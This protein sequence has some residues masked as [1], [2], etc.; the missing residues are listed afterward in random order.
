MKINKLFLIILC[1]LSCKK[2]DVK[3][4]RF[5]SAKWLYYESNFMKKGFVCNEVNDSTNNICFNENLDIKEEPISDTLELT[6]YSLSPDGKY[7]CR[8]AQ[9]LFIDVFG[10][11][12]GSDT[13][14]YRTSNSLARVRK[15]EVDSVLKKFEFMGIYTRSEQK[16]MFKDFILTNKSKLNSF[17]IREAQKKGYFSDGK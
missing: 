5:D 11:Y 8:T 12:P 7:K 1:A 10:F 2:S 16:K 3:E 9:G 4:N 14:T 13:V 6:I 15:P 17:I